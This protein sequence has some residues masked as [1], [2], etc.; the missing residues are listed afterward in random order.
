MTLAV[1]PSALIARYVPGAD[2]DLVN[3]TMAADPTWCASDL[4]RTEVMLALHRIAGSEVLANDLRA[5]ARSDFD[6]FV[7][8][9][10]DD[11]CIARATELGSQYGLRTV[12]AIHLAAADRMPRPIRY[13]TLDRHQIPAAAAL[14]FDLVAPL[15]R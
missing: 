7:L 2:R 10:V 4:A 15:V 13:L 9:P 12:D 6:A 1:D 8:V 3:E 11:R 5:A 14:G